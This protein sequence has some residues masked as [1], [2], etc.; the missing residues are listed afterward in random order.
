M[1]GAFNIGPSSFGFTDL[2]P[3]SHTS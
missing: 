1:E 3:S 2:P